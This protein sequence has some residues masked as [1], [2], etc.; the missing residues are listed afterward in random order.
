M[1]PVEYARRKFAAAE[2]SKGPVTPEGKKR[3]SS[4]A[5]THGLTARTVVLRYESQEDY[6][7]LLGDLVRDH[8]RQ[9]TLEKE[10]IADIAEQ[11]WRL[12]R[13]ARYETQL[14]DD[15]EDDFIGVSKQLDNLRRYRSSIERAF[16]KS[17]DQLRKIQK[18]GKVAAPATDMTEH[19]E[20]VR[21]E[22]LGDMIEIMTGGTGFVSQNDE[23]DEDDDLDEV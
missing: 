13:A 18:Q 21:N 12:R 20:Q 5:L 17:I 16:H 10:L 1:D 8:N 2:N 11:T 4:N 9:S 19:D 22:A 7:R 3:S 6:D 14:F 15:S 23:E